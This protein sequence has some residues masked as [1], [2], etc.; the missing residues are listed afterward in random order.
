MAKARSQKQRN[1][2]LSG[3]LLTVA[4]IALAIA[5]Y[6]FRHGR[7]GTGFQTLALA[8]FLL[9][10]FFAFTKPTRCGVIGKSTKRPCPKFGHGYLIGCHIHTWDKLHR[11]TRAGD[12]FPPAGARPGS[13]VVVHHVHGP[14]LRPRP[15][16]VSSL[17]DQL[18]RAMRSWTSRV[19]VL[20]AWAWI[21]AGQL[22][23]GW[24]ARRIYP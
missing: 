22:C 8:T 3:L 7:V 17:G 13:G 6:S 19:G 9:F 1:W 2:R 23:L 5:Y 18:T 4:T 11:R 10:V 14:G 16:P 12:S 20:V 24:P 15:A 21:G